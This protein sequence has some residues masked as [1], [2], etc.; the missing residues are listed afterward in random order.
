MYRIPHIGLI[1]VILFL[2]HSIWS[3]PNDAYLT[4]GPVQDPQGITD[5]LN[6][7]RIS[8]TTQSHKSRQS[9][10]YIV[11]TDRQPSLNQAQEA[12]AEL[13]VDGVT[14]LLYIKSGDYEQR[15]SAGVF[16]AK[17]SANLRMA[18]LVNLGYD[19]SVIERSKRVT[20]TIIKVTSKPDRSLQQRL[21]LLINDPAKFKQN[22]GLKPD[23]R[24][25]VSKAPAAALEIKIPVVT[26]RKTLEIKPPVS[27][28]EPA[29]QTAPEIKPIPKPAKPVVVRAAPSEPGVDRL[30][31]FFI[32]CTIVL[33]IVAFVFLYRQQ[34]RRE[35]T[36]LPF[37][38]IPGPINAESAT[39][40][41]LEQYATSLLK[42]NP[43]TS[44]PLANLTQGGAAIELLD[45]VILLVRMESGGSRLQNLA[46][47]ISSL[48]NDIVQQFT[49]AASNKGISLF[50]GR[51]EELPEL[52]STDS[53]KLARILQSLITHCVD[54]TES[55]RV[56]IEA[57][58]NTELEMLSI[59][60]TPSTSICLTLICLRSIF[61]P[62]IDSGLLSAC[63]LQ[64]YWVATSALTPLRVTRNLV[65]ISSPMKS[66][67]GHWTYLMA[68]V[69]MI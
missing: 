32:I 65:S 61:H 34:G 24:E 29:Q 15:I 48:I 31:T 19:F 50:F 59:P 46:F 39:I 38:Q 54:Q 14:D 26:P 28:T 12:I 16:A 21:K 68:K 17:Q 51:S 20:S 53:G 58:Y 5:F 7:Q 66:N 52:V 45:D 2:P 25:E 37:Q 64:S 47:D 57:E 10:G 8:F 18:R 33:A 13:H 41:D 67:R 62:P 55:G 63:D 4:L 42:G 23:P 11:V 22:E 9:L 49:T 1:I 27:T 40:V 69:W 43:T 60:A 44:T 36:I 35:Q 30:M 6:Q 56:L 3:A